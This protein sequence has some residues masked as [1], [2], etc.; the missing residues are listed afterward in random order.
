[1]NS[2]PSNLTSPRLASKTQQTTGQ[3]RTDPL[4]VPSRGGGKPITLTP[5]GQPVQLPE[6]DRDSMSLTDLVIDYCLSQLPNRTPI[7]ERPYNLA[8]LEPDGSVTCAATKTGI[9]EQN[10]GQFIPR[11]WLTP[12]GLIR[13]VPEEE[14]SNTAPDQSFT[15]SPKRN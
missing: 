2:I 10:I 13:R 6:A 7:A 11:N 9:L 5:Y 4:T 14:S 3:N 12:N 8:I 15:L 1:M